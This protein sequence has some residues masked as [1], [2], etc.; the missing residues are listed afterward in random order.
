[1]KLFDTQTNK[2]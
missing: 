1:M 2:T